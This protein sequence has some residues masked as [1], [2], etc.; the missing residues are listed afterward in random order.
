VLTILQVVTRFFCW[1]DTPVKPKVACACTRAV[2]VFSLNFSCFTVKG[3]KKG[4]KREKKKKGGVEISTYLVK[5]VNQQ[6]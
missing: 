1:N 6:Y 4:K 2:I 3:K 5:Q